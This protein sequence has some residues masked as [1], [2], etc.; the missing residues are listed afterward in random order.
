MPP[1]RREDR[2]GLSSLR[3]ENLRLLHRELL[4]REDSLIPESGKFLQL[5]DR[6]G[7]YCRS[8]RH[9]LRRVLLCVRRLLLL[10][11]S[12]RLSA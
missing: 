8:G 4:F 12:V 10:G 7:G 5:G 1:A 3:S 9:R 11:P 2:T 6:V